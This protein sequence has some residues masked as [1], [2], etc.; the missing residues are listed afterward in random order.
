MCA[1]HRKY[2]VPYTARYCTDTVVT[3]QPGHKP[4]RACTH[5]C[6]HVPLMTCHESTAYVQRSAKRRSGLNVPPQTRTLNHERP[7]AL[8]CTS[9]CILRFG[10][11]STRFSICSAG[12]IWVH[13][14]WSALSHLT[15][16]SEYE[17]RELTCRHG[18]WFESRYLP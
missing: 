17:I 16:Y 12:S 18:C 13:P 15:S 1:Q 7:T 2:K 4:V 5:A 8:Y 3:V 14:T 11:A 9:E 10:F 6:M